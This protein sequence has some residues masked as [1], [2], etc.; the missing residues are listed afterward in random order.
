MPN[1]YI[2][3]TATAGQTVW[4]SVTLN[5]LLTSHLGVAITSAGGTVYTVAAADITVTESP[6]LTVTIDSGKYGSGGSVYAVQAGDKVRIA[7]TTPIDD[8]TRTF[9]DG[10]VLKASDLNS[11]AKQ[12][13]FSLQEQED[14]GV[15]SLPV[16]TDGRYDAGGRIIKNVATPIVGHH[17]ATMQFVDDALALLGG[18][19]ESLTSPESWSLTGSDFTESD[20]DAYYD[21]PLA[22]ASL[23]ANTFLVEVGGVL[24]HPADDYTI[25]Q[26]D[27]DSIR[28]TLL[29]QVNIADS[30][31]VQV[32]NFGVSRNQAISPF[33]S[34]DAAPAMKVQQ[35]GGVSSQNT[36]EVQS[37]AAVNQAAFTYDG[38]F[39]VGTG[40][41]TAATQT[42]IRSSA[43]ENAVEVGDYSTG[44]TA[45]AEVRQDI[46]GLVNDDYGQ[47]LVSGQSAVAASRKAIEVY[48][49]GSNLFY[50]NYGGNVV[51]SGSISNAGTL[52]NTGLIT[53]SSGLS[54]TSDALT[55]SGGTSLD[56]NGSTDFSG[57]VAISGDA[58]LTL[59]DNS[60]LSLT[61][62]NIS[63][64]T[65][66][67]E[68]TLGYVKQPGGLV[69]R[70][71]FQSDVPF[72]FTS[73]MTNRTTPY[74]VYAATGSGST[75]PNE[76]TYER[77]RS[78][79][80]GA[81]A[82]AGRVYHEV[83]IAPKMAG[84]FIEIEYRAD[85]RSEDA[86]THAVLAKTDSTSPLTIDQIAA[87]GTGTT[88]I[89]ADLQFLRARGAGEADEPS[90]DLGSAGSNG[91]G[92]ETGLG[93]TVE[94]SQVLWTG[95][96]TSAPYGILSSVNMRY[97]YEVVG[98]DLG[99]TLTFHAFFYNNHHILSNVAVNMG[100]SENSAPG[101]HV[102]KTAVMTA[103]EYWA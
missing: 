92:A 47:V 12:L 86:Y 69:Q 44:N 37:S 88:N 22:P 101:A 16:D 6:S 32:R 1:S 78:A 71:F 27:N 19:L 80:Y 7:R 26:N 84:N 97:I 41:G 8:L 63:T 2:D 95:Q 28:L 99:K 72:K 59:G 85:L 9:N 94:G 15:G 30:E 83:S 96:D 91:F 62:G 56:V 4:S 21:F 74:R 81:D 60:D 57:S 75:T 25:T 79:A 31:K 20:P 98:G 90:A 42:E 93:F 13:L 5:Y 10:S 65:G 17:V 87:F 76:A 61:T 48:K 18:S 45:G 33:I 82:A 52:T 67:I 35:G 68:A 51:V 58:D 24:Q 100:V 77:N 34:S 64:A 55:M 46:N 11:Q 54:V 102:R 38:K 103:T 3:Y 29:G 49:N 53:A 14:K 66:N 40:V 89:P 43:A 70:R 23:E 36:M 39:R 73:G 50:V